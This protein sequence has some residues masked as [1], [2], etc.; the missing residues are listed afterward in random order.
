MI[1]DGDPERLMSLERCAGV[2]GLSQTSSSFFCRVLFIARRA[3]LPRHE[4]IA[5]CPAA[6][7]PMDP[8]PHPR[9]TFGEFLLEPAERRLS[10]NGEPVELPSKIFDVLSLLVRRAG[11]LV[12][13][14]E[15]HAVLWPRQIVS[16]ATLNKYIW[17]LRRTLG[18]G[19]G[20]GTFIETVPRQGYRFVATVADGAASRATVTVPLQSPLAPTA[21]SPALRGRP[22][23]LRS[24]RLW[25]VGALAVVAIGIAWV[26]SHPAGRGDTRAGDGSHVLA[27]QRPLDLR[28]QAESAW[29]SIALEE[30]VANQ[31]A[32]LE[33]VR[34]VPAETL[35]D[36]GLAGIASAQAASAPALTG[37]GAD[38]LLRGTYL[39]LAPEGLPAEIRIDFSVS[40]IVG[41]KLLATVSRSGRQSDL[42]QLIDAAGSELRSRLGLFDVREAA[43][44]HAHSVLPAD[45]RAAQAYAEGL[46]ALRRFDAPLA[47]QR[48]QEA[49]ALANDFAPGFAALAQA[50]A[51]LGYDAR[52]REAAATALRLGDR[53][54][55]EQRLG[56]AG[57][58]AELDHDWVAA[59]RAYQALATFV[60]DN[61][62]YALKLAGIELRAGH[63]AAAR[64]TLARLQGSMPIIANDPRVGIVRSR[65]LYMEGNYAEALVEV[66]AARALAE[67]QQAPLLAAEAAIHQGWCLFNLGRG[68]AATAAYAYAR[69]TFSGAGHMIGASRAAQQLVQLDFGNAAPFDSAEPAIRQLLDRARAAGY[70]RGEAT[71]LSMLCNL[72]WMNRRRDDGRA[73]NLALLALTTETG[74]RAAQARAHVML[75]TLEEDVADV[76]AAEREYAVA[77][78]LFRE[79]GNIDE[80]SWGLA[81]HANLVRLRADFP[82]AQNLLEQALQAAQSTGSAASTGRVKYYRAILALDRHQ[83]DAA[84]SDVTSA[85]VDYGTLAGGDRNGSE[86]VNGVKAEVALGQGRLVEAKAA[87][88][89]SIGQA[90]AA[91]SVGGAAWACAVSAR[92]RIESG[93]FDAARTALQCA[94]ERVQ[95]LGEGVPG[96]TTR[97]YVAES[98]WLLG[99]S[100]AALSLWQ[101]VYDVAAAGG[102]DLLRLEA[103]VGLGCEHPATMAVA[104]AAVDAAGFARGRVWADRCRSRVPAMVR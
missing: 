19:N 34:L 46:A 80:L 78:D 72:Y 83:L 58:V 76:A 51:Q 59:V 67:R 22:G 23:F 65:S 94:S 81:L 97:L 85:E 1:H 12:G 7:S 50:W 55:R 26:V 88:D 33:A 42:V 64:E 61:P 32:G 98:R 16:E 45:P 92:I 39:A 30:L 37:A 100:A 79:L 68:G 104:L 24:A 99:E 17:Q 44:S 93:E 62:E 71:A 63:Y 8:S 47:S 52:A 73:A 4:S 20:G 91:R 3:T 13:K 43:F 84:R 54:P 6:E 70:K 28:P 25:A 69:D 10:R 82:R 90:E 27:V 102:L 49:V 48:L 14:D 77:E 18:D 41:G 96:L 87:I 40:E 89:E 11:H 57:Q 9:Y 66:E 29:L 2:A 60:P 101:H 56:Y 74:D 31:F 35:R 5:N 95:Q 75:A 86:L 103:Q 15:F 53:L 21:A 38:W 36:F